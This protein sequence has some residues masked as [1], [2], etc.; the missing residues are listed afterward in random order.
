MSHT[1]NDDIMVALD[2]MRR[3]INGRLDDHERRINSLE[4]VKGQVHRLI[5]HV[6]E[7]GGRQTVILERLEGME[8]LVNDALRNAAKDL[9]V[10]L[11]ATVRAELH[12]LR[13]EMGALRDDIRQR[14]CFRTGECER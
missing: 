12:G 6:A 9:T 11:A 4:P 8:R 13:D 7:I 10:Q 3:H 1:S 2:D 5:E 14:P